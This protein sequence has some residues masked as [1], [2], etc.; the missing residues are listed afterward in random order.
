MAT[1]KG[2]SKAQ[3]IRNYLAANPKATTEQV[4]SG[5][6]AEGIKIAATSVYNV[7]AKDKA[8]KPT[9]KNKSKPK[10]KSPKKAGK[11]PSPSTEDTPNRPPGGRGRSRPYPQR[12]LEEALT[13]PAAI[14]AKNNGRPWNT[15][16]VAKA[17]ELARS[18]N[19]FFYLAAAS[20]DYGLTIGSRDS[21]MIEL[22]P[23][24]TEIFF[25]KDEQ[26][27]QQKTIDAFMSVD[28]FK[29][30]YDYYGGSKSIPEAEFFS[31]VLQKEFGLDCDSSGLSD[32]GGGR[33]MVPE[34][35]PRDDPIEARGVVT[36]S[37]V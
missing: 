13:V 3:A 30:V 33:I 19:K 16:D 14:K 26:T 5:L 18:N 10:S 7:R 12:T 23:L 37:A 21:D 25:A 2:K 15:D 1:S 17:I 29:K 27:S 4:V 8:K 36:T 9:K 24:G 35:G 20:R 32:S 31:N 28:L 22:A 6:N 34:G 11:K